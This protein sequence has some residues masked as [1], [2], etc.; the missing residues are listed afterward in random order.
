MEIQIFVD[1]KQVIKFAWPYYE[2]L[3]CQSNLTR[4]QKLIINTTVGKS[5]MHNAKSGGVGHTS[6]RNEVKRNFQQVYPKTAKKHFSNK[7]CDSYVVLQKR[8]TKS[9]F[10]L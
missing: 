6:T 1:E 4:A 9:L 2:W 7:I 8:L 10:K 3:Y 5:I